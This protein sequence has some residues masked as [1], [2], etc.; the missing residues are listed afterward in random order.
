MGLVVLCR[1]PPMVASEPLVKFRSANS[2]LW[3]AAALGELVLQALIVFAAVGETSRICQ[4]ERPSIGRALSRISIRGAWRLFYTAIL[5]GVIIGFWIFIGVSLSNFVK[6]VSG[7]DVV[8]ATVLIIGMIPI[9]FFI[10]RYSIVLQIVVLEGV[11]WGRALKRSADL[12]HQFFWRA[13]GY[14]IS[15]LVGFIIALGMLM[16]AMEALLAEWTVRSGAG[17][18][19]LEKL[20]I[21]LLF[22]LLGWPLLIIF[23][24]LLYYDLKTREQA[25]NSEAE[26]EP[27]TPLTVPDPGY[28]LDQSTG[29]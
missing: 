24:T 15:W 9:S 29:S 7:L 5:S 1:V 22:A 8:Y 23:T 26:P 13:A 25:Q 2:L 18:V 3:V 28:G 14:T 4:G 20:S 6:R 19:A 27:E 21:D 11:Y 12:V 17:S 16:L 10:V